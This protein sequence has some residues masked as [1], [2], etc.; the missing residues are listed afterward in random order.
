MTYSV[1]IENNSGAPQNVAIFVKLDLN[2]VFSLV[3]RSQTINN[4]GNY[5]FKWNEKA[6]GLGWGTSVQP[7]DI[8]VP[9]ISGHP[10][11]AVEPYTAG[12]KNTQQIKYA[13]QGFMFGDTYYNNDLNN[14]LA[15]ITD[16]SFTVEQSLTMSV[17]LYMDL[18]PALAVQGAPNTLYYFDLTQVKYYITVTNLMPGAVLP[19]LIMQASF[20]STPSFATTMTTPAMLVFSPG[21]TNL[22]YQLDGNL[23]FNKE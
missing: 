4:G 3:W 15:I 9:F 21:V 22:R 1:T 12:G 10:P 13:N 7:I 20:Y 18:F 8:G 14:A 6:F 16:S 11:V 2:Q 23:T 5:Q 17:A 19:D